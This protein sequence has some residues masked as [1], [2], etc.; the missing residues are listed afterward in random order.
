[1]WGDRFQT[2]GF[3][4][5]GGSAE[6]LTPAML[7]YRGTKGPDASPFLDLKSDTVKPGMSGGA[8]LN[9]RTRAVCGVVVATRNPASADGGL[10]VPWAL[11]A[12]R[13]PELAEANRRFHAGDRRWST[14]AVRAR[15]SVRFRLPRVVKGFTGRGPELATLEEGFAARSRGVVIQA[16]TG[17]AGVG[18]TQLAAR[19]VAAHSDDYDVVA[20]V[21]AEDGGVANLAELAVALGLEVGERPAEERA[22]LALGWLERSERPWLLVLDNVVSPAQFE[23]CCPAAG[24]NGHVLVTSRHRGFAQF[25][26][27]LGVEVFDDDTGADYLVARTLRGAERASA[28][29]LAAAL[30]GLPLALAHG[31]AFCAESGTSFEEYLDALAGLPAAEVFDRAQRRSTNR[32]WPPRGPP[33]ST[34]PRPTPPSP[35]RSSLWL[36]TWLPSASRDRCSACSSTT[37]TRARAGPSLPPS[38]RCTATRWLRSTSR[39]SAST[40]SSR[41]SCATALG[42][43]LSRPGEG[44]FA[45]V[46]TV[47]LYHRC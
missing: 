16:V 36:P 6:L 12:A 26:G 20:W 11:L 27:A 23:V 15:H 7:E 18:K 9:V 39:R 14:A 10:A 28:R 37:A 40:A 32:R 35:H 29:R 42:P 45:G 5:E 33:P 24:G 47:G 13:L 25:D 41:K 2:Y 43:S 22:A 17:L 44:I 30:G 1:M 8:L 21:R 46:A 19:Y 3:P 38:G 34:P 31:G 4:A